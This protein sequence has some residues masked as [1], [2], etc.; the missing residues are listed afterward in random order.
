MGEAFRRFLSRLSCRF[1]WQAWHF[2]TFQPVLYRVEFSF[3]WLARW[4]F[5]CA[6][7]LV[8]LVMLC[9]WFCC[10]GDV[11]VL[12]ISVRWWCCCAGDFSALVILLCWWFCFAGDIVCAGD[13]VCVGDYVWAG[14]SVVLLTLLRWWLRCV[15]LVTVILLRWRFCCVFLCLWRGSVCQECLRRVSCS[16]VCQ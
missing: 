7:D 1:A 6:G 10:A 5:R 3:V 9:W 16:S 12:V 11:V 14:D 2:V 8:V 15:G 13:V 4:W